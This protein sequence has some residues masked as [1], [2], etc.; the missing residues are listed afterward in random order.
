VIHST[1]KFV[2]GHSD[3][4]GGAAI[5]ARDLTLAQVG[6]SG[7]DSAAEEVMWWQNAIGAVPGPFDCWLAHRG[8]RTLPVRVAHATRSAGQVA[9]AL[10]E[11]PQIT[12]VYYPGLP[13]HP[14]HEIA[15]RQMSGFGA[16]I[17]IE[18]ATPVLARRVAESTTLFRLAVSLGAAESLIEYP[19]L[20]THESLASTA[21]AAPDKLVRLAIGLE[22]PEDILADLVQAIQIAHQG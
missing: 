14:G 9:E 7:T 4:V 22:D 16:V 13:S 5:F 17:S 20:M 19:Y 3:L 18:L 11:I 8:L 21:D 10:T 12:R 2:G 15:A 6:F 1:T